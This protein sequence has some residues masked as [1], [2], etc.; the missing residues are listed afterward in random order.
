MVKESGL[1]ERD[2]QTLLISEL[3]KQGIECRRVQW[4][5][6]DGAPDLLVFVN[7]GVWIE[8]KAPGQKVRA[9]Q[10]R[11]HQKM[12][13]ADMRILIIDSIGDVHRFTLELLK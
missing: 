13:D 6:R 10:A 8:T 3:K 1:K 11:E 4:Q 7:G 5:G 9:N 12:R 2:I